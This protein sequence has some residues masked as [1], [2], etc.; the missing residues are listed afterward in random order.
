M[1]QFNH[2]SKRFSRAAVPAL[3]EV[4]FSVGKGRICGLLGH[5]GAGKS[6]ALGVLLGMI[7]PDRGEAM[8]GGVAVQQNRESAIR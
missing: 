5:N 4:S 8:I 7:H 2:V 3:D 1:L 6:T